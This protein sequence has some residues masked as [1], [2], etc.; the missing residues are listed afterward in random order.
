MAIEACDRSQEMIGMLVRSRTAACIPLLAVAIAAVALGAAF[1]LARP[2]ALLDRGF[3]S[4]FDSLRR[5]TGALAENSTGIAGS[6]HFRL[7][8]AS[9][10]DRSSGTPTFFQ[11]G[12]R[13]TLSGGEGQQTAFEIVAVQE[14]EAG[15]AQVEAGRENRFLLVVCREVGAPETR[16]LRFIV[17]SD[18]SLG[19][20]LAP[21]TQRLL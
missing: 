18:Q 15:F 3:D 21:Q 13:I 4:A 1:M 19:T 20:T 6:P 9:T 12:Q 8:R 11:V 7:S 16:L 2:Q 14:L 17:D 5:P 10:D